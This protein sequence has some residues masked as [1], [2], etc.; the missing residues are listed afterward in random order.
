MSG[1]RNAT[2]IGVIMQT[3]PV[4][5]MWLLL[6]PFLLPIAFDDLMNYNRLPY[7]HFQGSSEACSR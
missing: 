2:P 1:A 6:L 7:V 5:S 3:M 4:V